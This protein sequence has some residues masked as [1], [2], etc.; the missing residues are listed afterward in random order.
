MSYVSE[1]LTIL[2][3]AA[4]STIRKNLEKIKFGSTL[5]DGWSSR[6]GN[7]IHRFTGLC[8][9]YIDWTEMSFRTQ[10]LHFE[11]HESSHTSQNLCDSYISSIAKYMGTDLVLANQTSDN[12]PNE[13][14]AAQLVLLQKGFWHDPHTC[15][16]HTLPLDLNEFLSHTR[17]HL[18]L[19]PILKINSKL[20]N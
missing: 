4:T 13:T 14:Q 12:A 8:L 20:L 5:T 6:Q 15:L 10:I 16:A 18:I 7:S 2:E 11:V 9:S 17:F 19:H 3:T 1:Y